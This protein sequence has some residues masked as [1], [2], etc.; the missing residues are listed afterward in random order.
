MSNQNAL[1][2][3]QHGMFS[4]AIMRIWVQPFGTEAAQCEH[5][6]WRYQIEIQM[7]VIVIN[8]VLFM[9]RIKKNVDQNSK[10]VQRK[11]S[12]WRSVFAIMSTCACHHF[13]SSKKIRQLFEKYLN[14]DNLL[15]NKNVKNSLTFR[16]LCV[17]GQITP[18]NGEASISGHSV[19]KNLQSARQNMGY[20]PQFSGLPG[21]LT[22]R[23]VLRMYAR[24]R[25][26]PKGL[27]EDSVISL[28]DRLDLTQYADRFAAFCFTS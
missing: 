17:I 27:I 4:W 5:Y 1:S 25:G 19:L 12:P 23:E 13:H 24:I 14:N 20:C 18:D 9:L 11:F 6:S 16:Q 8:T 22:G 26:M 15:T 7:T 28:L 3:I 21:A 10:S 2:E